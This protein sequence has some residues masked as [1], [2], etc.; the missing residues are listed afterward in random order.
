MSDFGKIAFGLRIGGMIDPSFFWCWTRFL[1]SGKKRL[2]DGVLNP[3]VGLP[4]G[5]ACNVLVGWFLRTGCDSLMFIDDD[6]EFTPEAIDRLRSND[7][8]YDIMSCMYVCRKGRH[9]PLVIKGRHPDTQQPR[10]ADYKDIKG[11][12]P[13]QYVG[14]GGVIVKRWVSE[15]LMKLY[16]DTPPFA[17]DPTRGEDGRFCDDARMLGAKIAVNTDVRFGHRLTVAAYW[18]KEAQELA[19]SENDYGMSLAREQQEKEE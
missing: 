7:Y 12:V 6:M 10:I 11:V 3:A 19:Y 2:D 5:P 15:E 16:A 13:V 1:L 17:F 8:G 14:L 4:H 9:V 18:N